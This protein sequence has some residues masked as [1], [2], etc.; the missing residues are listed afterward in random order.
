M[1]HSI[2]QIHLAKLRVLKADILRDIAEGKQ[3]KADAR[4]RAENE[5]TNWELIKLGCKPI[6]KQGRLFK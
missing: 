2:K 5:D 3:K 4:R 1:K 6:G